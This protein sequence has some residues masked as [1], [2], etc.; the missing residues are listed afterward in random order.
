MNTSEAKKLSA[1]RRLWGLLLFVLVV[2]GGIA[3][4]FWMAQQMHRGVPSPAEEQGA[5]PEGIYAMLGSGILFLGLVGYMLVLATNAFT[6]N[7]QQPFVG[8]HAAKMRLIN[9]FVGIAILGGLAMIISPIV[10]RLLRGIVPESMLMMVAVFVPFI[11]LQAFTFWFDMFSPVGTNL[12][13]KRMRAMGFSPEHIASGV[14]IGISDP[15]STRKFG[16]VEDDLG[17]MWFTPQMLMYR[18]DGRWFDIQ[19]Q[20]LLAVE[21][22][23]TSRSTAAYFGAVHVVIRYVDV[24]GT[25]K[26]LMLHPENSWTASGAARELNEL[27]RK[28]EEWRQTTPLAAPAISS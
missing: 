1:P 27:A 18:G 12:I 19:R 5:V 23:A 7:F 25:Q 8:S 10:A 26:A 6:F 17:M 15:G 2:M 21:R 4:G 14:P 28:L 22:Q 13:R 20:H 11:A 9:I 24:D 3:S 16:L